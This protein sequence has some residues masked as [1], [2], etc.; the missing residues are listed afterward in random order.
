[1]KKKYDLTWLSRN[2]DF[3]V[4]HTFLDK[5]GE[6]FF[7]NHGSVVCWGAAESE[8][9]ACLKEIHAAQV[10]SYFSLMEKEN[11]EYIIDTER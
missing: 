9:Q 11:M 1:L 4:I 7:F 3:Q 10:N 6:I 8:V 5:G 2:E